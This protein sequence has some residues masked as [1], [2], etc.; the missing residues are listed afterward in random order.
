MGT[1]MYTIRIEWVPV[2]NVFNFNLMIYHCIRNL[3]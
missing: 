3:F 1:V 2:I